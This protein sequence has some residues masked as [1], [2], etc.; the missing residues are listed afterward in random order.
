MPSQSLC[1]F[2]LSTEHWTC[3]SNCRLVRQPFCYTMDSYAT[4]SCMFSSVMSLYMDRL[5]PH[6]TD[7]HQRTSRRT[8]HRR[9]A[10]C[11]RAIH[12]LRR[13]ANGTII[14]ILPIDRQ[15]TYRSIGNLSILSIIS[16]SIPALMVRNKM[17][18]DF[19]YL[20][21]NVFRS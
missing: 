2:N 4:V 7:E 11:Q 21:R 18:F 10:G 5:I 20:L 12:R 13:Y 19:N 17:C 6:I 1:T 16:K 3:F 15:I 8:Q 14:A 9:L